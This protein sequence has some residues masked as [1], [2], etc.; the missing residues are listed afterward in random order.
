MEHGEHAVPS[1]ATP[2]L[3]ISDRTSDMPG[4]I[5]LELEILPAFNLRSTEVVLVELFIN[6][7]T[8]GQR[9]IQGLSSDQKATFTVPNRYWRADERS[10]SIVYKACFHITRGSL[11]RQATSVSTSLTKIEGKTYKV[12]HRL[13]DQNLHEDDSAG[14][15]D[16]S[17]RS[18]A[19]ASDYESSEEEFYD[20][21]SQF[22]DTPGTFPAEEEPIVEDAAVAEGGSPANNQRN[23][24]SGETGKS[25][26]I[27]LSSTEDD[28]ARLGRASTLR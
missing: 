1:T 6:G 13:A 3:Y 4:A 18:K 10:A 12:S 26:S 22:E 27:T 15:N 16:I 25:T 23:P 21:R 9:L 17:E 20:A 19:E 11:I 24:I 28:L 14:N 8:R 7:N 5:E 2:K